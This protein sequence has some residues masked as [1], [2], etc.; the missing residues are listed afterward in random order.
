MKK[1]CPLI[2]EAKKNK[3]KKEDLILGDHDI[4]KAFKQKDEI[5]KKTLENENKRK[6]K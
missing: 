1:E 4:E 6:L 3:I 2:E 5:I